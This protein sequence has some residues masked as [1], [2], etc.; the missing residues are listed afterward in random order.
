MINLLNN[1][2]W[3][4]GTPYVKVNGEWKEATE[5]YIKI[6]GTWVQSG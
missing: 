2:T 3:K 4:E 6:N 5:V 1:G